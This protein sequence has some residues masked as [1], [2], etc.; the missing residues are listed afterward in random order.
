MR[1]VHE[2]AADSPLLTVLERSSQADQELELH[3]E[4]FARMPDRA[5]S[6]NIAQAVAVSIHTFHRVYDTLEAEIPDTSERL[7]TLSTLMLLQDTQRYEHL[8]SLTGSGAIPSIS[9][10]HKPEAFRDY[11]HLLA[12]EAKDT[13]DFRSRID[14]LFCAGLR[15]QLNAFSREATRNQPPK[16]HRLRKIAKG[17]G[18]AILHGFA[19]PAWGQAPVAQPNRHSARETE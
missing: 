12:I 1:L 19:L 8:S 10:R 5:N 7:D 14:D 4:A 9:Q 3:C 18:S 2:I 17:V 16:P 13:R 15:D 6:T 11:V